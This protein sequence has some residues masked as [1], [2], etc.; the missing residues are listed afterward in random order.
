M[1]YFFNAYETTRSKVKDTGLCPIVPGQ[2]LI[3]TDSGD[4]FYDTEDG[5][6]KQLTDIIDLETDAERV[7]ILTPLDKMYFVKETAHFWRY[8]NGLWV[9]LSGMG[10]TLYSKEF[11]AVDWRNGA[12]TIPS[13]EHRL[14]LKNGCVMAKVYMLKNNEYTDSTLAVMDTE[15]STDVNKNVV[16][17]YCGSSYAGR[18]ILFD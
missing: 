2:Y 3:C 15:V 9:D 16:L 6:R 7:S 18:V 5:V 11:T 10:I 4:V 12:I 1:D 8:L 17:S 14:N 13:S